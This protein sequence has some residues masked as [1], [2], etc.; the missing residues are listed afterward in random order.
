MRFTEPADIEDT[1][2][3]T[4]NY[5]DKDNNQ[6]IY[7]PALDRVRRISTSRKGGR[8]VGS[9]IYYEDLQKREVNEDHHR[10]LGKGK[11]GTVPTT[12]L[13]STPIDPD[14]SVYSKWI[15]WIHMGSLTPLQVDYYKAG[16]ER[17]VKRLRVTKL[18]K[19]QGYWTVADSTMTELNSGHQTRMVTQAIVYDQ[20]LPENLFSQQGLSDKSREERYRP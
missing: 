2:L 3:L 4:Y 16:G 18:K 8:F 13:E 5:P 10:I 11:V 17:P 1:A 12:V 9:D 15:S 6:W 14:S 7:L 19:I 20:S